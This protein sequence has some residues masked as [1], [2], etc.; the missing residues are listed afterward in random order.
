MMNLLLSEWL[1]TKR[2]PIRWLAFVTPVIFAALIIWYFSYQKVTTDT[3]FSIF[4]AFFEGWTALVIP[5]GA[6]LISGFII[7]QEEMAGSFNGFLGS[8]LPRKDLYLGKLTMLILLTSAS[9]LLSTLVLVEGLGYIANI[10]VP[11]IIFLLGAIM[12][13]IGT[14]PIVAICLWMSFAWGLGA[15]MGIGGGGLLIAALMITPLGDNIWQFVP[16]A[17]PARLSA[18]PGYYL[19]YLPGMQFPPSVISSG[20]VI[21]ETIK[22]L[23]SSAA[24]FVIMLV[25]GLLWFNKWEGRKFYD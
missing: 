8:K 1:K 19:H 14:I 16:W 4:R 13:I 22:G 25:G 10:H 24:F 7:H 3:P 23:I 20:Y 18:L 17:L 11:W 9:T 2:T 15:S 5:I 12:T 6:G 21:Y